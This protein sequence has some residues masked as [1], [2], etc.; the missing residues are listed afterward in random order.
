MYLPAVRF[1]E[2]EIDILHRRA[3]IDGHDVHLT[4]LELGLLYL[5][6]INGG[7]TLTRDE[8]LD[9]LWGIDYVAGSNVV[10]RH[11]HTL[12]AKLRDDWRWPRF[13]ATVPGKGYRFVL[14]ATDGISTAGHSRAPP[15]GSAVE[16]PGSAISRRRAGMT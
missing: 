11:V 5:L 4:T 8:I 12:R 15:W 9:H 14:T 13:I 3:R 2:L 1:G 10:D 6:A 7:R 16:L